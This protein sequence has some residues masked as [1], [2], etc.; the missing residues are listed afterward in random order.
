VKAREERR[1]VMVKARMRNGASWHDVCIV[2]LSTRGL[3]IQAADPPARGSYLEICR[4][5]HV[6]V[7][8]VMWSKGHRAGLKAQDSIF[9][10]ALVREAAD[11]SPDAPKPAPRIAERRRA[12]RTAQ[13]RHERSRV[14]GRMFEF[15]CIGLVA[16]GLA[17]AAFGAVEQALARPMSRIE[18]ALGR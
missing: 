9:V 16:G 11:P 17:V 13:Q 15:A 14:A 6:I 10:D 7:A 2:N 3:G 18:A 12:P 8:R 1:K 4:G 5:R